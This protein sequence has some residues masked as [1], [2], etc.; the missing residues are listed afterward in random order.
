M[1]CSKSRFYYPEFWSLIQR[2][3]PIPMPFVTF[4]RKLFFFAV[5]CCSPRPTP[6]LE[7]HWVAVTFYLIYS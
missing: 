4:R 7:N 2:N 1:I 5:R 3:R 6:N